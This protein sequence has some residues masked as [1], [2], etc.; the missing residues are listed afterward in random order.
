MDIQV[1]AN[2][3]PQQGPRGRS[4]PRRLLVRTGAPGA[5]AGHQRVPLHGYG[6]HFTPQA[7]MLGFSA[8]YK[9]HD[10]AVDMLGMSCVNRND[11]LKTQCL[12]LVHF[13]LKL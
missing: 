6:L 12:P 7:T 11:R 10:V 1:H 9:A 2:G 5:A 8:I 3:Q 13:L 4:A